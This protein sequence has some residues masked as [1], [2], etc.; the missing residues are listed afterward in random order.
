[1][2]KFL[3]VFGPSLYGNFWAQKKFQLHKIE[4][5]WLELKY[6]MG[7]LIRVLQTSSY[8]RQKHGI[9]TAKQVVLWWYENLYVRRCISDNK[10]QKRKKNNC[11]YEEKIQQNFEI[12][13]ENAGKILENFY[14]IL[15]KFCSKQLIESA[16]TK[17]LC[18]QSKPVIYNSKCRFSRTTYQN[19]LRSASYFPVKI[20]RN[21]S[22][23]FDAGFKMAFVIKFWVEV[24][25]ERFSFHRRLLGL[26]TPKNKGHF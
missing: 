13:S 4:H 11:K 24:V 19:I 2:T 20:C 26:S 3:K 23:P 1:M 9:S 17:P 18:Q 6:K 5:V 7:V 14:V 12:M 21:F 22:R 10:E 25:T 8:I 16:A 15:G